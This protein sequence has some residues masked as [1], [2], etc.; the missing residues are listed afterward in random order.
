MNPSATII[1]DSYTE[2][3][4]RVTT[5]QLRMHRFILAEFNTHRMFS[6]NTS[7][8]RAIPTKK[9]RRMV[10]EHPAMP[11]EWGLNVKGMQ[12]HNVI[13]PVE[14]QQAIEIW[15]RAAANAVGSAEEMEKVGVHKQVTN[16]LLEPFMWANT[17]VTATEWDNF[18]CLRAHKDAQPEFR[19]LA[20][21]MR[22]AMEESTPRLVKVGDWHLPYAPESD[23]TLRARQLQ[24]VARC[25]RVSYL[26]FD[27]KESSLTDDIRLARSLRSAGHMSPFEHQCRVGFERKYYYNLRGFASYRHELERKEG[28]VSK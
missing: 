12:A 6:R 5:M 8:S 3:G 14:E 27:G 16:R 15:K 18:Y 1:A 25:A 11:V 21:L 7:S 28:T 4:T 19:V 22:T 26:T 23:L 13:G 24:S 2:K 17:I 9:L 20:E 10:L